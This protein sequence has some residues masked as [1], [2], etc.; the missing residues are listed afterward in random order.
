MTPFCPKNGKGTPVIP[1]DFDIA[2]GDA[3]VAMCNEAYYNVT[4]TVN[5]TLVDTG[6]SPSDYAAAFLG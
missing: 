1:S 6:D 4:W 2:N 5:G 3:F